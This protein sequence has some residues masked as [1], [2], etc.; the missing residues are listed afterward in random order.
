MR[1]IKRN[2]NRKRQREMRGREREKAQFY[3]MPIKSMSMT[4]RMFTT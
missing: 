1:N 2:R 3:K 4:T